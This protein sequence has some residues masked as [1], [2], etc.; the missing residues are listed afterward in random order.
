MV[1]RIYNFLRYGIFRHPSQYIAH[2]ARMAPLGEQ[3][4]RLSRQVRQVPPS[5]PRRN[6]KKKPQE[7]TPRRNPKKKPQARSFVPARLSVLGF[8]GFLGFLGVLGGTWRTWRESFFRDVPGTLG[9]KGRP[10]MPRARGTMRTWKLT[11][12]IR[13]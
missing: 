2:L 5:T 4:K 13:L 12:T 3:G 1:S 11:L 9:E 7:E 6:P 8:L 10:P